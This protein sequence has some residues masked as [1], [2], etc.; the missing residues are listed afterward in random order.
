MK[1][2]E[3]ER[4]EVEGTLHLVGILVSAGE[5]YEVVFHHHTF[6]LSRAHVRRA[7]E[8]CGSNPRPF[9]GHKPR[10]Y[11]N[12]RHKHSRKSRTVKTR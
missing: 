12:I 10:R 5:N 8:V 1:Q 2:V 7:S 9:W 6:V 11:G 3:S 4:G